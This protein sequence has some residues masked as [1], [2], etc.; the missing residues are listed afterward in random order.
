MMRELETTEGLRVGDTLC[1]EKIFTDRVTGGVQERPWRFFGVV[2]SVLNLY[3]VEYLELRS[4]EGAPKSWNHDL[5]RGKVWHVTEEPQG[6]LA[7][8][9]RLI[10][11][12]H[13]TPEDGPGY[14]PG[15]VK[16]PW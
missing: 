1:I 11:E 3:R 14:Q 7:M 16:Q 2:A 12:G 15:N 13:L 4:M 5:R 9:M 10:M 8:K 6:V